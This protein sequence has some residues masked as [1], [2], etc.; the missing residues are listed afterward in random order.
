[1]TLFAPFDGTPLSTAALGRA[2][3]LATQT[4]E[5][6]VA[7][8]VVPRKRRAAVDHGWLADEEAF[9][10]DRIQRRLTE[11]VETVAPDADYRT[12]YVAGRLTSGAIARRLR[13]IARDVDASIVVMGS[14]NVGRSATPANTVSGKVAARLATDLYIVQATAEAFDPLLDAVE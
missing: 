11:R 8:T 1:M 6:L 13:D 9:D 4:G 14:T 12:E 2:S 3:E 7:A 10:A 5:P